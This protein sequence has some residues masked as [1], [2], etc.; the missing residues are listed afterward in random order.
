MSILAIV[1]IILGVIILG[2][3]LLFILVWVLAYIRV[4]N[5]G[6]L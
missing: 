2:P 4:Q 6:T 3:P 5:G 1:G